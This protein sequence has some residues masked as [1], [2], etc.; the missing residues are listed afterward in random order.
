MAVEVSNTDWSVC[1]AQFARVCGCC[2]ALWLTYLK[3]YGTVPAC[4]CCTSHDSL[5]CELSRKE[6][7][8]LCLSEPSRWE[9]YNLNKLHSLPLLMLTVPVLSCCTGAPPIMPLLN[10][11]GIIC[12]QRYSA[13]S[14]FQSSFLIVPKRSHTSFPSGILAVSE[15]F[16]WLRSTFFSFVVATKPS[17]SILPFSN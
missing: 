8:V 15:A 16:A 5:S 6:D 10:L 13:S 1:L 7:H 4:T 14:V 12:Y 11:Q 3:R 17:L 9:S 2:S